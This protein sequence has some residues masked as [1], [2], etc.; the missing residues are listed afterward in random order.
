MN[1][2][3]SYDGRNSLRALGSND[4]CSEQNRRCAG[5]V[6]ARTCTELKRRTRHNHA[7]DT[8]MP[9]RAP[10]YTRCTAAHTAHTDATTTRSRRD[11]ARARGREKERERATRSGRQR[12]ARRRAPGRSRRGL[13]AWFEWA[14]RLGHALRGECAGTR[15]RLEA[16]WRRTDRPHRRA[17]RPTRRRASQAVPVDLP[18]A[19]TSGAREHSQ[20][21]AWNAGERVARERSRRA[22][23]GRI[24]WPA[25]ASVACD[26]PSP[27]A[28]ANECQCVRAH[29]HRVMLLHAHLFGRRCRTGW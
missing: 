5:A 20:G 21:S 11:C 8:L 19:E 23:S 18:A 2:D 7:H 25:V 6:P 15:G 3:S 16:R 13:R 29:A 17:P 22:P 10:S 14:G 9:P 12:A 28:H 1:Y 24:Y 26:P 27:A 4:W